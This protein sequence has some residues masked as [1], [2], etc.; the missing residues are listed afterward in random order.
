[1]QNRDQANQQLVHIIKNGN[2]TSVN[3]RKIWRETEKRLQ[4]KQIQY[5]VYNTEYAGHAKEIANEVLNKYRTR[6]VLL[7]VGG[8]GMIHEV[9][10]GAAS[11]PHAVIACIAAG[12]GNDYARGIQKIRNVSE[13]TQLLNKSDHHTDVIDIGEIQ[14]KNQKIFFVNSLGLGFDASICK[15]VNGS[16]QKKHFQKWKLGKFIYLYYL[17][18]QLFI[19][20]PFPLQIEADGKKKT[21]NKVWF[22]V[23]ANQPYFGGGL[24]IAP[25]ASVHDG[26]FHVIVVSNIPSFLFLLMFATVFWGGHLKMSKYVEQFTCSR[27]HMAT[28]ENVPIQA[29]GEIVGYSE[30]DAKIVPERLQVISK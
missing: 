2:P 27:I 14:Y 1:M 10:N 17:F 13:I 15:A 5:A 12:S 16:K 7:V 22:I 11:Y 24:K 28:E 4:E 9:I 23:V 3:S 8:D 21:Y 20:Q 18:R 19:F 6:T 30:A 29:D 26:K 25:A